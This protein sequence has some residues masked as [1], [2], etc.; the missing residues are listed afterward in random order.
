M[1][2]GNEYV[3]IFIDGVEIDVTQSVDRA[4]WLIILQKYNRNRVL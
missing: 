2:R 3:Q 4:C 1:S